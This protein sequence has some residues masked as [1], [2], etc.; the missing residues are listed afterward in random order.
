M[1]EAGGVPSAVAGNVGAA[2]SSLAGQ[3]DPGA[4]IVCEL[5]SFQLEE[6]EQVRADVGVLLNVTP[7][8]L[9]RHGSSRL[10]GRQAPGV[11]APADRHRGAV[12]GRP[13]VAALTA[14][15][16]GRRYGWPAGARV[17]RGR[18]RG[19]PLR[20]PHNLDNASARPLWRAPSARSG[21]GMPAQAL[22]SFARRPTASS[23]SARCA[24]WLRQRLAGHQRRGRAPGDGVL[25]PRRCTSSSAG[26]S[27]A[28][29][30]L[31]SARPAERARACLPHRR[32][33]S[34][35]AR[36]AAWWNLARLGHARD[37]GAAGARRP[38]RA[39]SSCS[40]R[41]AP[42]STSSGLRGTAARLPQLG[43]GAR[44]SRA[45]APQD[46]GAEQLLVSRR[47]GSWPSAWSWST[48]PRPHAGILLERDAVDA[49]SAWPTAGLPT[50]TRHMAALAP[51]MLARDLGSCCCAGRSWACER[52]GAKRWLLSRPAASRSALGAG[53][54]GA[55]RVR[56]AGPSR[57]VAG[58][59][60]LRARRCAGGHGPRDPC[61][62]ERD[63]GPRLGRIA[64]AWSL[65]PC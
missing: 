22:R 2:L 9:D 26:R 12:R 7:D 16:A 42:R 40:R 49:R 59:R 10:R 1:L 6:V 50:T 23:R 55:L 56:G 3:I 27:R 58:R 65:P 61:A 5:S 52:N 31:R 51:T 63:Q 20:G 30:S 13:Y 36:S 39:T 48:R 57:G 34:T 35:R 14:S 64:S 21:A 43:G 53:Q 45:G 28:A 46:D 60:R 38:G 25:R 17:V 19:I 11:R 4:T 32:G 29:A 8:H 41:P 47:W 33:R 62:P 54:G 37:R 24:A 15:R 44:V 18:L